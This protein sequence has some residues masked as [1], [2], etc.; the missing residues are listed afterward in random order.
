[1]RSNLAELQKPTSRSP[2]P[3]LEDSPFYVMNRAV[4]FYDRE[5]SRMLKAV[6]VDIPRWRVLLL[7]HQRGPISIS[8]IAEAAVMKQSTTTRVVQRMQ[9]D[10]LIT[11]DARATDGRVTEVALTAAGAATVARIGAA[12]NKV[13]EKAFRGFKASEITTLV[14]MM[15]RLQGG[16]QDPF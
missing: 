16:L 11:A 6:G 10:G 13:Y 5:M 15:K 7:A 12:A 8:E 14:A 2:G 9:R 4:G 3:D 1:M